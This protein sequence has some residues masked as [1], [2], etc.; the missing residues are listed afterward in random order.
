MDYQV[1]PN[2]KKLFQQLLLQDLDTADILNRQKLLCS[3]V[4]LLRSKTA[5]L[6]PGTL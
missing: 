5:I 2:G 4:G 3:L 6:E 1:D